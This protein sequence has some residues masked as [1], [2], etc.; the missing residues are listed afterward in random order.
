MEAFARQLHGISAFNHTRH[1][2][3]ILATECNTGGQTGY[4]NEARNQLNQYFLEKGILL[5]PLGNVL[6]LIPP[7]VIEPEQLDYVF[8]CMLQMSEELA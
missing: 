7:Y 8:S 3:G 1:I 2:G 4:F 5:R 6:Y